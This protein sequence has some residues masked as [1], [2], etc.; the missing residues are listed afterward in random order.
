MTKIVLN[1]VFILRGKPTSPPRLL[2]AYKPGIGGIPELVRRRWMQ[3]QF[4]CGLRFFLP[5]H[6]SDDGK[7]DESSFPRGGRWV[8]AVLKC[9]Y[10]LNGGGLDEPG[11]TRNRV[12]ELGCRKQTKPSSAWTLAFSHE[13]SRCRYKWRYRKSKQMLARQLELPPSRCKSHLESE[14][15]ANTGTTKEQRH[16]T[17]GLAPARLSFPSL[18][19]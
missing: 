4:C 5:I 2:K 14:P 6:N 19:A 11:T 10:L 18:A 7:C 13:I 12:P 17:L 15:T 3:T 9:G 1:S 8:L 16:Q